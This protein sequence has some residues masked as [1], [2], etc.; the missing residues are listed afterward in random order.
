MKIWLDDVRKP[1]SSD[2]AWMDSARAV[3]NALKCSQLNI[4]QI[5]LDHD[6]GDEKI[7]GNGYQVLAWIEEQVFTST[8]Y[9]P[10]QI[11]IHTQN[12]VAYQR[13]SACRTSIRAQLERTNRSA[14]P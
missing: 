3:I 5:D 10:P 11:Q 2:W 6:L 14:F 1:P 9:K 8:I 7:Y 4:T 13:M 12:P